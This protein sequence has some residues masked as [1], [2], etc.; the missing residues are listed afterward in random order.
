VLPPFACQE[1]RGR[2]VVR[3]LQVV[4]DSL[5]RASRAG[6]EQ[7]VASLQETT[8]SR[9]ALLTVVLELVAQDQLE[10][11]SDVASALAARY[12]GNIYAATALA[13]V[14]A[15]QGRWREAVEA[16]AGVG[17]SEPWPRHSCHV[18]GTAHFLLGEL[19]AARAV[20]ERGEQTKGT[21]CA[22]HGCLRVVNAVDPAREAGREGAD[23][24]AAA[25]DAMRV[26]DACL[27]RG[28]L[29]GVIAALERAPTYRARDPQL[30]ARLAHAY[31]ARPARDEREAFARLVVFASLE[32]SCGD[33][34]VG[35]LG[36]M[37]VPG[38]A[39]TRERNLEVLA[40]ARAWLASSD[41]Y[42]A[43]RWRVPR[44]ATSDDGREPS[45]ARDA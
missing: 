44:A 13:H 4:L 32:S 22:L 12:A 45:K 11:A 7:W 30:F 34:D 33:E 38:G 23:P 20:W 21:R 17:E 36:E 35:A 24:F 40:Q 26:A 9:D 43:A 8:A 10:P 28:E 6:R 3:R 18:L 37:L 31:L 14:R 16:F 42:G 25:V 2:T 39:W 29:D 41:E 27:A 15:Y 1:D 5:V 19:D